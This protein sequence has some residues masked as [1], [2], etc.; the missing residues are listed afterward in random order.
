MLVRVHHKWAL[1]KLV[2]FTRICMYVGEKAFMCTEFIET[3]NH[4]VRLGY[5]VER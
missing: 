2:E 5:E 1:S 4:H 3:T